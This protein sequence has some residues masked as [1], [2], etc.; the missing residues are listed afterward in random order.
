MTPVVILSD[1]YIA[2]GSEPWRYPAVPDL[3]EIKPQFLNKLNENEPLLPYKRNE[4]LVRPW[5]RPGTKGLEHRIGGLEKQ[6]ETGNVSYDP[7]NHELMVNLRAAKVKKIEEEITPAF[8]DSGREGSRI[9]VLGWGSSY[10]SIKMAVRELIADGYDISHVH[11]RYIN[12]FPTNLGG[13]LHASDQ[14]LIPEM[15]SGQLLQMVR[16]RYLVPAIG[17]SKVQGLPF[18]TIELKKKIIELIK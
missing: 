7:L 18:T 13:L 17:Y 9:C 15:N 12:P 4:L 16:A 11:L 1:G 6:N 14:V 5:I 2:N 8:P 10:G 3:K